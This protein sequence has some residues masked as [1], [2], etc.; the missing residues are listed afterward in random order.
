[1]FVPGT[2][3]WICLCEKEHLW[4]SIFHTGK[5]ISQLSHG[6]QNG[7]PAK[8]G[9]DVKINWCKFHSIEWGSLGKFVL[10]FSASTFPCKNSHNHLIW[11]CLSCPISA[12]V[13]SP[14]P[15][16][17]PQGFTLTMMT[18]SNLLFSNNQIWEWLHEMKSPITRPNPTQTSK[19]F[20]NIKRDGPRV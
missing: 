3:E 15:L 20:P 8:W 13:S 9:Y 10:S 18:R 5:D 2:E 4:A 12:V 6:G 7:N 11:C 17:P 16:S 1:M 19:L 14:A